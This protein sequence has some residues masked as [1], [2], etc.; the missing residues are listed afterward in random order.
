MYLV[1]LIRAGLRRCRRL[2]LT[3]AVAGVAVAPTL[4]AA[5]SISGVLGLPALA[6]ARVTAATVPARARNDADVAVAIVLHQSQPPPWMGFFRLGQ[7]LLPDVRPIGA[8]A[9]HID[10]APRAEISL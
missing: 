2:S 9:R 3:V 6:S 8:A 10:P 4:I 5:D 7:Q 1:V